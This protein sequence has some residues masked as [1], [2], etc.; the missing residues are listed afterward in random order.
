MI[1]EEKHTEV[2]IL[3]AG[4][5]GLALKA[6][7][8][9]QLNVHIA[10]LN[11]GYGITQVDFSDYNQLKKFIH[12]KHIVVSALPYFLNKDVAKACCETRTAYFDLTEDVGVTEYVRD[13]AE[14]AKVT[15]M[16]QCG[17]APGAINVIGHNLVQGFDEVHSLSLRVGAL[18]KFPTNSLK[19]YLSWNTDGVVNEYIELCDALYNGEQIKTVPMEGLE[20]ITIEGIEYEAFNTSG[21][22]GTL[23]DSLHGTVENLSYK[24]IRYPGHRDKMRV[25]LDDL[26]LKQDKELLTKIMNRSVPI[27]TDDVVVIFAEAIGMKNGKLVSENYTKHIQGALGLTAIQRATAMGAVAM[28]N[29]LVEGQFPEQ[30]FVKQEDIDAEEFFKHAEVY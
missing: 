30:G 11:E 23:C 13:I 29:M 4:N 26:D 12:D 21:G 3:G 6:L 10:D 8:G 22:V 20:H 7:L 27:T 24:T 25:L 16:P 5:I 1:P 28:I 19:Y 9:T 14:D 15:F 17:L 2:A 18:P